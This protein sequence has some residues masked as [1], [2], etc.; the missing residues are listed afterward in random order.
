MDRDQV[1]RSVEEIV[2]LRRFEIDILDELLVSTLVKRFAIGESLRNL[3]KRAGIDLVDLDR[4]RKILATV[5]E[6]DP[7]LEAVFRAIIDAT[8]TERGEASSSS[9]EAVEGAAV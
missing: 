4:E 1:T 6:T 9:A 5:R 2:R 8:K 3:R 7:R